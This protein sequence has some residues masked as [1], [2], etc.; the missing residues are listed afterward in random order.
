MVPDRQAYIQ[1]LEVTCCGYRDNVAKGEDWARIPLEI[2]ERWISL[3][4]RADVTASEA[5]DLV[6]CCDEYQMSRGG[7]TFFAMCN[8][9]REW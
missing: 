2:T 3:L 7:L 6:R 1:H 5:A 9:I 4:Q 8:T